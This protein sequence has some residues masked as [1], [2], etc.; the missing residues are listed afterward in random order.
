VSKNR[1]A[2]RNRAEY[3]VF[4][5]ARGLTRVLSPAGLG[6]VGDLLGSVYGTIGG[7]RR[8]IVDFNLELAF[9]EKSR[10]ER[11][12]LARA[13]TRH[14]ARSALDAIRIQG[15]EPDEL[16]Q[17]VKISGWEHVDAAV[18]RGRGVFF[19][20][21]HIGSWEVAA[22]VTGLKLESGLAVVNRPLDNPLLERELDHLRKLYGNHVFGKHNMAREMLVQIRRG[23]GV[24]ILI[25]QRVREDQGVEVPFFGHPAWTHP[26]LAR[27][28]RKTGAAVV[29]TFA[30][31]DKPGSYSLRYENPLVVDELSEA[32]CEDVPLT[33][34]YMKI[35]EG[36]IRKNP[37]Q[38]LWYHDRWKQLRLAKERA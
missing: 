14:F 24:G 27:M 29:P 36:A 4:R 25:D 8:E 12:Q 33:A 37:D 1:S 23:G 13:V 21:A 10:A 38:W 15:L 35:L 20:T 11:R 31:R 5:M 32:E 26:V 16:L 19:L 30:L 17:T 3:A 28:A 34:R 2:L 6:R 18:A 9:P 22:L 7:R